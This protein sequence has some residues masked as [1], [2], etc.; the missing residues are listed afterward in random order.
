L[1]L[2]G[3]MN[4][5]MAARLA[6]VLTCALAA[7]AS[8]SDPIDDLP[9]YDGDT[10]GGKFDD[11]NCT[12][13]SYRA[14][15]KDYLASKVQADASPCPNG[16]DASYRLWA[17]AVS[18]QLQPIDDRYFDAI[19]Q[20]AHGGSAEAVVA[21]GTLDP[22][23]RTM[24]QRLQ[25]I[26]PKNAGKV[27][28]GAWVEYL[29]QPALQSATIAVGS[30]ASGQTDQRPREVTSF[31]AEWLGYVEQ[32]RPNAVEAGGWAI[33]WSIAGDTFEDVR[34]DAVAN[35]AQKAIDQAWL[36]HLAAA[37]PVS[38]FDADGAAFQGAITQ[39][40]SDDYTS[41]VPSP[42]SWQAALLFNPKAGGIL[43]YKTWASAFAEIAPS[44]ND[45]THS[46]AQSKLLDVIV[47]A[48]PCASGT[49]VDTLVARLRT[50]LASAGADGS[51]RSLADD[52]VPVACAPSMP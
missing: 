29:Y 49:D 9:S 26:K 32:A 38:T 33:W 16:N 45:S 24:L 17:Y 3:I 1:L 23:A 40:A 4:P 47:A 6:A 2:L 25:L 50:G 20:R 7:C 13:A 37:A 35:D 14:F 52:A 41:S 28:V 36:G 51:G 31:E 11:P 39:G 21:A 42:A 43:S 18:L 5:S 34:H 12:D 48:R 30:V 44:F 46:D 8:Q 19:Q 27:G 22:A 10:G 15:L